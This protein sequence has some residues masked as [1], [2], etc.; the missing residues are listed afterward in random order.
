MVAHEFL[1]T[2][3]NTQNIEQLIRPTGVVFFIQTL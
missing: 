1:E 3:G 2:A